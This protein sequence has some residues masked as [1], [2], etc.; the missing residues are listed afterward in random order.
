[1]AR[2]APDRRAT[3]RVLAVAAVAAAVA[4]LP[5]RP[6]AS[7]EPPPTT[8]TTTVPGT[9][10]TP[11]TV[12]PTTVPPTTVPPTTVPPTSTTLPPPRGGVRDV[13]AVLGLR[14]ATHSWDVDVA[15]LDRDT[16]PDL[17]IS[18]HGRVIAYR[19]DGTAL[20]P[21]WEFVGNDSHGCAVGDV[22]GD[23][24]ADLYCASGARHGLRVKRN[25]LFLQQ[26][27]LTFERADS[28][29]GVDDPYGRGRHPA[30]VDVTGDGRLDLVI[31]NEG[32][33]LDGFPSPNRTF[34]NLGG[35]FVEARLGL[36]AEI[37]GLCLHPAGRN[38]G[39]VDTVVC[40]GVG[41]ATSG[42]PPG[43]KA[44][45]RLHLYRPAG[46]VDGIQVVRDAAV[47]LGVAYPR[48]NDA[49]VVDLD[50]D[51]RRDLVVVTG[52]AL[53]IHRRLGADRFDPDP[54]VRPLRAGVSVVVGDLDGRRGPDLLV[55]QGC[56]GDGVN[57]PD[58]LLRNQG[59]LRF[60]PI[61]SPQATA[62]CGDRGEA[63]DLDGDGR[64]EF[65]VGNGRWS[66]TGRIQVLTTST[67][68]GAQQ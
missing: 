49:R 68:L 17:V 12:P 60:E 23:A 24:R 1:M 5:S 47:R 48:V 33:R 29:W 22:D 20:L 16:R 57:I 45:H 61:R 38:R 50:G 10:A 43:S 36:T 34:V 59:G 42:V 64:D 56:R 28:A 55:V 27:G 53:R 11:T 26:D 41:Q 8:V 40:G 44:S 18:H 32:E 46:R 62:G 54:L 58:V 30:L 65:V 9:T 66:A 13:G 37:G 31:T 2:T 14:Q 21:V 4:L 39:L 3:T 15:D 63:V 67:T 52:Q 51:R 7:G 19:N 35:H 25:M 6:S